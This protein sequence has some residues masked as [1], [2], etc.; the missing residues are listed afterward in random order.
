MLER[1]G[2]VK[3]GRWRLS[4]RH[5]SV[6]HLAHLPGIAFE[7]VSDARAKRNIV[8]AFTFGGVPRY[9]GYT[10]DR[11]GFGSRLANYRY[12]NKTV[13]DTDNRL[14]R[15]ITARLKHGEE[16]DIWFA[17]PVVVLE[18][19]GRLLRVSGCKVLEELLIEELRPD[20]NVHGNRGVKHR[21]K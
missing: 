7:L 4:N 3:V 1:Y 13:N 10:N 6:F 19:P 11:S 21:N 17:Q 12:G 18:V 9:V 5:R 8:Y 2:L 16:V 15:V 20:L 14:K